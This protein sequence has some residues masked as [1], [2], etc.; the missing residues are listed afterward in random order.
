M[1]KK[2]QGFTLIEI[3]IFLAV[4]G[5]IFAA[6]TIGVQNSIYQQRYN[7]IV[8]NFVD[9]LGNI[10]SEVVSV[11]SEGT[12]RTDQAIYGKLVTF[13]EEDDGSD[14]ENKQV[15]HTYNVVA[16]AVNSWEVGNQ[17]TL[18]LL[19]S[20]DMGTNVVRK[21]RQFDEETG[22][23]VLTDEY[24]PIGMTDD[25]TPRWAAR[26]EKT[27]AYT[28]FVGSLLI[29]RNAQT[30]VVRTYVYIPGDGE[31]PISVR[32]ALKEHIDGELNIFKPS[33]D[34]ESLLEKFEAKQVDFCVNPNGNEETNTR[35]DVRIV[36]GARDASGIEKI[37]FDSDNYECRVNE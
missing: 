19:K 3:A 29:V 20:D 2:G 8:D 13:G 33:G 24:E 6:V 35:M 17:N 15:I 25:Y 23:Y 32:K 27:S 10:Y 34:G 37:S 26:I 4:T 22:K 31:S 21:V 30:G 12:G 11:E 1:M 16:K 18:D 28:D 5:A 7:D 9:F 14:E 36:E